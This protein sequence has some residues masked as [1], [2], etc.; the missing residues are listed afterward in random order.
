MQKRNSKPKKPKV[1]FEDPQS[2]RASA[3]PRES[4]VDYDCIEFKRWKLKH[5]LFSIESKTRKK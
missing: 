4:I 2:K 1:C 5:S 3:V